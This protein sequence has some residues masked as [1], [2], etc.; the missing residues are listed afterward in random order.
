MSRKAKKT[1]TVAL[2][3]ERIEWLMKR[4][5]HCSFCQKG[6]AEV[7]RL[8]ESPWFG[9]YICRTCVV[10]CLKIFNEKDV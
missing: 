2:C 8:I 1:P 6:M 10:D 7:P 5:V 9:A 4:Q 3:I